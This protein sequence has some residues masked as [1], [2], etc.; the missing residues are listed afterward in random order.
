MGV[1]QPQRN[2]LCKQGG[3]DCGSD[4][5]GDAGGD[6]DGDADSC[7][8]EYSLYSDASKNVYANKNADG[9]ANGYKYVYA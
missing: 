3:R 5:Y 7:S 1:R 2:S 9:G 4:A 8:F 6:W